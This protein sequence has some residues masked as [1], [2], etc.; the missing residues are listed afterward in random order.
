M[1][2]NRE[3]ALKMNQKPN[4]ADAPASFDLPG[5]LDRQRRM[6]NQRLEK[7]LQDHKTVNPAASRLHDAMHYSLMSGG[8]RLRPVLCLAA[9]ECA[10]DGLS[11][12]VIRMA[13]ALEM[14]HTYSLV[15][16]DLPA[17]DDD[18]LRRGRATCH[19]R[20]DEA[21][22][23]LAGDALLTLA[24]EILSAPS[25]EA[26]MDGLPPSIQLQIIAI[27]ARAAGH[28]GMIEGQMLDMLAQ[29]KTDTSL[30]SLRNIHERK[31][32]RMIEAAVVCGALAGNA[33]DDGIEALK[34]YARCIGLAFQ[35]ADDILNVEGDPMAMGKA[36]GT[37]QKRRK[38]TYPSLMGLEQ[39]KIFAAEQVANALQSLSIFDNKADPL[40][41]LARYII[42][43]KR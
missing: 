33:T 43:R 20:F 32:G 41:A 12:P 14:I 11:E 9:A 28:R 3:T 27:I 6:V 5:Y 35:V 42:E 2:L 4:S 10:G 34:K 25:P 13:C 19:I 1:N 26:D 30:E 24:F 7:C 15:H 36:T 17:M 39:S 8:K 21:T 40:R 16:D 31:T 23:V 37:D 29:G 18:E 22:A 38:A